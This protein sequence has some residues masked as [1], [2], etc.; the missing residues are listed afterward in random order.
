MK[1]RKY[2]L[3]VYGKVVRA[4]YCRAVSL[5]KMHNHRSAILI[6]GARLLK[7]FFMQPAAVIG[8]RPHEKAKEVIV[9]CETPSYTSKDIT[10]VTKMVFFRDRIHSELC[11]KVSA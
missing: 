11:L 9:S 1:K 4:A 2:S 3:I 5:E 6:I 7:Y 8:V 10:E